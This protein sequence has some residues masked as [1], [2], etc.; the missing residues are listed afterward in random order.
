MTFE[1]LVKVLHAH[2]PRDV[3]RRKKRNRTCTLPT[4]QHDDLMSLPSVSVMTNRFVVD[5]ENFAVFEVRVSGVTAKI[6]G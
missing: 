3:I 2:P 4:Q 1:E 6:A 5:G